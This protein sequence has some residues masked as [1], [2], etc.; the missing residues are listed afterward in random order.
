MAVILPRPASPSICQQWHLFCKDQ[1]AWQDHSGRFRNGCLANRPIAIAGF[2][3]G[4]TGADRTDE[5]QSITF[6][7]AAGLYRI[8]VENDS[9]GPAQ[10]VIAESPIEVQQ[11]AWI[12][13]GHGPK[14]YPL[15]IVE[16]RTQTCFVI[17]SSL[18]LH[19][20]GVE[21]RRARK[22]VEGGPSWFL[23]GVSTNT[24]NSKPK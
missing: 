20:S 8:R 23:V 4:K 14:H 15:G 19:P 11:G 22:R 10:G 3:E 5:K 13:F 7:E 6:E 24:A 16:S 9:L 1:S 17:C 12:V 18:R 2:L 21:A